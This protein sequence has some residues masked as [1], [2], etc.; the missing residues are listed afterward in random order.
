MICGMLL[1]RVI[2]PLDKQWEGRDG[3][4][5][6]PFGIYGAFRTHINALLYPPSS[7]ESAQVQAVDW[8]LLSRVY[9]KGVPEDED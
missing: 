7:R 6:V 1:L 8:D 4:I 9:G 3:I 5:A 2:Y